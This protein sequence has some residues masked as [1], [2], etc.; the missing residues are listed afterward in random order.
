MNMNVRNGALIA[1]GKTENQ[2]AA[3]FFKNRR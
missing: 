2:E 3:E 1:L